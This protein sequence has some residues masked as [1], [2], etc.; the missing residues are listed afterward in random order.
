MS[1]H[2]I[3]DYQLYSNHKHS[4]CEMKWN[5]KDHQEIIDQNKTLKS[6]LM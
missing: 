4:I 2:H 3:C 5:N 6:N 1:A